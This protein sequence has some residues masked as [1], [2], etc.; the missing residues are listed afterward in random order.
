MVRY[1][2]IR[3]CLEDNNYGVVFPYSSEREVEHIR[4]GLFE[5]VAD[6][7]VKRLAELSV[8]HL[9]PA[10]DSIVRFITEDLKIVN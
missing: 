10:D 5:I 6:V 4:D 7:N 9:E 3:A 2:G 8:R 1:L